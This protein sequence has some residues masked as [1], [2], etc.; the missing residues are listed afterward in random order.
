MRKFKILA[1]LLAMMIS[2]NGMAFGWGAPGGDGSNYRQLQEVGI[3]FN[4][5]GATIGHGQPVILDTSATAGTTLGAYITTT[6]SADSV[7]VV[8]CARGNTNSGWPTASPIAVVTKG[9]IDAEVNGADPVT[10]GNS[11]GTS[12]AVN[13][14]G[15]GSN[16]GIALETG[17]GLK[18]I[19]V[20]P[21][22]A[23]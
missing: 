10:A 19:W 11:V 6:T 20:D 7:L 5:S 22:G 2:F 3:F 13:G 14:I 1:I 23:D 21:T 16:L 12:G 18:F 15:G 9:P 4:N 8:G 17:V